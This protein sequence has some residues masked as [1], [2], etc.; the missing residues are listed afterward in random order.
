MQ[1]RPVLIDRA[2]GVAIDRP[3]SDTA[4][5]SG[6]M[7]GNWIMRTDDGSAADLARANSSIITASSDRIGS[8]RR[9]AMNFRAEEINSLIW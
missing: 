8:A 6:S 5:A 4:S 1:A 9:M 7:N 2:P 3:V